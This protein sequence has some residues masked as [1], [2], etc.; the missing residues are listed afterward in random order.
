MKVVALMGSPRGGSN[1]DTI[2]EKVLEGARSAGAETNKIMINDL[3]VSPCTGCLKCREKGECQQY[4]DDINGLVEEL[5]EADALVFGA[6]VWGGFIPGQLKMIFDRMVGA[7][8]K[9]EAS[10]NGAQITSRLPQKKRSGVSIAVCASPAK[11]M[12]EA[13]IVFFN[14]NLSL[15]ANGG[16]IREIRAPGLSAHGMV[17]M[18]AEDMEVILEQMGV[19]NAG[20]MAVQAEKANQDLLDDAYEIGKKLVN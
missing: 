17:K 9:I 11:E 14:H 5:G 10:E 8:V 12:T 15:H 3:Q 19:E 13:T 7:A 4:N 18:E 6:P 16:D 1:T 2:T 20:L